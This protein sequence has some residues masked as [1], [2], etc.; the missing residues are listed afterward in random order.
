MSAPKTLTHTQFGNGHLRRFVKGHH[1]RR[2]PHR[3]HFGS[4]DGIP[5]ATSP[6]PAR[7]APPSSR[8]KEDPLLS[9]TSAPATAVTPPL[10]FAAQAAAFA[11]SQGRAPYEAPDLARTTLRQREDL[12]GW[13][14]GADDPSAREWVY[15]GRTVIEAPA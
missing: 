10:G 13:H 7:P 4:A 15:P 12:V 9:T 1:P 14:G 11:R 8:S 6:H 3:R 5:S 2:D